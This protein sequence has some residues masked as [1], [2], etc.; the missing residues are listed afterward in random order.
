MHAET[1]D[2]LIEQVQDAANN[3]GDGDYD[4]VMLGFTNGLNDNWNTFY[5]SCERTPHF[6]A[7]M[8]HTRITNFLYGAFNRECYLIFFKSNFALSKMI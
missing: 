2:A 4:P 5:Q 1:I 6:R 3:T 8:N 7:V